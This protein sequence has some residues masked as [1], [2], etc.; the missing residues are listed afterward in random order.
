[1]GRPRRALGRDCLDLV[2]LG[3]AH[4]AFTL[5]RR[6]LMFYETHARLGRVS[7]GLVVP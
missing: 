4:A 3:L 1:V 7:S 5:R 2:A 6:A